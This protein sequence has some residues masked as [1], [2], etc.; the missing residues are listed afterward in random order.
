MVT[1]VTR[2][3]VANGGEFDDYRTYM[4]TVNEELLIIPMIEH[5]S[6]R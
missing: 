1:A 2:V 4:D 3:L 6:N 5:S